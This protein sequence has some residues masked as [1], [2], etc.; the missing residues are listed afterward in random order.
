[1]YCSPPNASNT[2]TKQGDE[3]FI[4]ERVLEAAARILGNL[5]KGIVVSTIST[6]AELENRH[7]ATHQA[8]PYYQSTNTFEI[9]DRNI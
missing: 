2:S 4:R 1:V 7:S 8:L 6:A 3:Q 9:V 5:Q